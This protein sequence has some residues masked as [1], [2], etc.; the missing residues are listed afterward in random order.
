L[1]RPPQR[2]SVPVTAED[3][4]I[5]SP[6]RATVAARLAWAAWLVALAMTAT[7]F[8][9]QLATGNAWIADTYGFPGFTSLF[10]LSLG[11]VGTV[12]LSRHP[13]NRV[14]QVM[15]L[16]GLMAAFQSLYTEYAIAAYLVPGAALPL[17]D[18]AAWLI[19]WAWL[20]FVFLAGPLLLSIFPDGEF[21][22]PRWRLVA[23]VIALDA[24]VFAVLAAFRVGPIDNFA[25]LDNPLGV[26]PRDVADRVAGPVAGGMALG[27]I[28]PAAS[29]VVRF[30]RS[31]ADRR[32]QL[33]W[34][35]AAGVFAAVVAPAGFTGIKLGQLLV[36]VAFCG[37]P[38]A[39]GIAVLRYRLYEIDT[40]INRALVY[41]L[42]TAIIAGIYTASIGV[43]QRL[44]NAFLG[45]NSEATIVVTTVLIVTAFTPIKGRL[46]TLVD[47]RFKDAGDAKAMLEPFTKALHERM[48]AVEPSLVLRRFAEL[49]LAGLRATKVEVRQQR[50]GEPDAVGIAGS[51]AAPGTTWSTAATAGSVTIRVTVTSDARG[52]LRRDADLVTEATATIAAEL[53]VG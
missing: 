9:I 42:L 2:G 10:A 35:A 21:L 11:T 46:Q 6:P 43:M 47:R 53:A 13:S 39:T 23:L 52:I 40:I 1:E 12:V 4:T 18:V 44:S 36:I 38:V 51:D 45:G 25:I 32:Q 19:A 41:G 7:A 50:A 37:I 17:A 8:L 48:W 3:F 30:R 34:I 16:G 49:L 20:P 33:K 15:L 29:L 5:A 14:G 24:A 31:D 26:I 27:F 22:S 28:L